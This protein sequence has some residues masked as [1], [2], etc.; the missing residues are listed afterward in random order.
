M[1]KGSGDR[2]G[3]G[4]AQFALGDAGDVD[5]SGEDEIDV[6][7]ALSSG[8]SNS[9]DVFYVLYRLFGPLI[10]VA[11][12]IASLPCWILSDHGN[13]GARALLSTEKMAAL[14]SKVLNRMLVNVLRSIS[15]FRAQNVAAKLP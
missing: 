5:D 10:L 1:N 3:K 11:L 15:K 13:V 12:E 8:E 9:M 2:K 6:S 4:K 14:I 7:L